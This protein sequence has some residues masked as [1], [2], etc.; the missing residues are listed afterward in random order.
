[1]AAHAGHVASVAALI[2]RGCDPNILD[3]G[4]RWAGNIF[5][6]QYL[7]FIDIFTRSALQLAAAGGHL[8]LARLL[9]EAGAAVDHQDEADR[10][11]ALHLAA[12]VS[13]TQ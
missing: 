10:L 2:D 5:S 12:E 11:T 1:M 9:L 8:E 6:K 3:C 7:E 4:G 13:A